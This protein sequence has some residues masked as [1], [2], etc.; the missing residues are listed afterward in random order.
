MGYT[1]QALLQRIN[2][3]AADMPAFY[4]QDFVNYRG[5]TTDTKELYTEVVAEWCLA[6]LPLLK[7]GITTIARK[8][9][10]WT[11]SHGTPDDIKINYAS[12]RR[13]EQIAKEMRKQRL[14]PLVGEILDYQT[15]L[16]RE[17]AGDQDGEKAGKIDLLA[18]DG[19]TLRILE[20]KKPDS[21]ETMLRCVLES[22]TYL[23]QVDTEKLI[24]DFAGAFGQTRPLT[25]QA[26]PFVFRG[27]AQW[28][29][30][31][32]AL[33]GERPHLLQLMKEL[34]SKPLY[35]RE[36]GEHRYGVEE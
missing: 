15:P 23:K 6:D 9:S 31:Q 12:N 34:N 35:V 26:C 10:Y 4:R 14:L 13:E 2:E 32:E 27:G 28:Q 11:R 24:G 36:V 18:Y 25:V 30:M 8:G 20:L 21:D 16:T 19:C 7:N 5:R 29:E 3:A 1:R 17:D 33:R 22:Y